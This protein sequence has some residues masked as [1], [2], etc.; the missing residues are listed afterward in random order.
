MKTNLIQFLSNAAMMAISMFIPNL[1]SD[2][3]ADNSQIGILTG[4]FAIAMF[5][6]SYIFGRAS[7]LYGRRF[8]VRLGLGASAVTFFLQV[9][10]DPNFVA[11]LWSNLQLLALSLGLA[12][13]SFGIFPAAL[14]V[15][16]YES[17][18]PMGKFSSF[19]SLGWA[20]GTFVAGLI[21]IYWGVF[22][23]CS[24]CLLLA[25]IISLTL[26]NTEISHLQVPL[27]PRQLIKK[28]WRVYLP[29]S[30][31]HIGANFIWVIY[32]LFII[33]VGGDKFWIGVIYTVNSI[34]Q[35]IVMQ[36]LDRFEGKKLMAA[37]LILSALTFFAF[38][39]AQHFSQLI[40]M[41]IMLAFSWSCL[42]VGSL[43]YLMKTNVEKATATGLLGSTTN[44]SK[45]FGSLLGGVMSQFFGFRATMYAATG[46][47]ILGFSLSKLR[48]R[49]ITEVSSKAPSYS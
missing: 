12:G 14:T 13:F 23:W 48:L 33:S 26:E 10:T 34:S 3:G 8:F 18:G 42:Y 7:D 1:A 9:L 40:P 38:S 44:L 24:L 30:L 43:I 32:P 19:G 22:I 35:F 20:V 5:S 27:F 46:L 47:T 16:V 15:Y 36:F 41:Q 4:V 45:V 29:F 28:N 49:E 25:F 37:G 31:R 6:S 11:P 2:L 39:F 17:T 21:Q